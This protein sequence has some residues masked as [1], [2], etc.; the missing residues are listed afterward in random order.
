[1]KPKQIR[2]GRL[3]SLCAGPAIAGVSLQ[4]ARAASGT[5][6]ATPTNGSW[7]AVAGEINWSTGDGT[8]PGSTTISNTDV[9]TFSN[10]SSVT[11]IAVNA[12]AS[13]TSPLFIGSI[14]FTGSG[15][16]TNYT[17]GSTSGNSL[18]ITSN[19]T[20]GITT[21]QLFIA[22]GGRAGAAVAI[23]QTID[24]PI[25]LVPQTSTTAGFHVFQNNSTAAS[26]GDV[27]IFNGAVSGGTTTSTVQLQLVGSSINTG[28]AVNGTITA[29]A[30]TGGVALYKSGSGNWKVT[31]NNTLGSNTPIASGTAV[32]PALGANGG[33]LT[34]TGNNTI[35]ATGSNN[36][37]GSLINVQGSATIVMTGTNTLSPANTFGGAITIGGGG[38]LSI[39]SF[40]NALGGLTGGAAKINLG[41]SSGS[42][43]LLY[44]G[45]EETTSF[46]FGSTSGNANATQIIDQS[47][48]TGLLKITGNATPGSSG[49]TFQTFT[50]QGSTD[51]TGEYAGNIT[52]NYNLSKTGSGTW[53][54]SGATNSYAGTTAVSG[55]KLVVNGNISTSIVNVTAGAIGG[56]GTI[57]GALT[58]AAGTTLAPG[59]SAGNLTL[60]NGLTL[61]G[62]YAWELAALST[63]GTTPGANFDTV[64][65]TAGSVDISGATLQLSL[66][67]FAPSVNSF[68]QTDQ[69]WTGIIN[70][71]GV[72]NLNGAFAAI[73]NSAWSSL[74]AFST[75]N[76]GNDVNLV[77]TAIPEP[78]S[79]TS[80]AFAGVLMLL[81]RRRAM[82]K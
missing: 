77:W 6:N 69:T 47:G 26:N 57:G 73:D 68:W 54:L 55:G 75:T 29:G 1:M 3:L 79:S 7:E 10:N 53:T 32:T 51:G 31:G 65:V 27:L 24:A 35:S 58:V 81:Y 22:G 67:A 19:A 66:G 63:D 13:N 34:L 61:A 82:R 2:L 74:G 48:T 16:A 52:G 43:R 62:S 56:T 30:A 28:N 46:A 50:L 41:A 8:F 9:A 12:T 76:T 78:A 59:N 15:L 17:I 72:G 38:T 64:T 71:T 21:N 70:N 44:T 49:T 45:T 5:W 4:S 18:A 60:G 37:N 11:S 39:N 40:A 80:A 42:G 25:L 23:T 33:I 20:S 36:G 14:G